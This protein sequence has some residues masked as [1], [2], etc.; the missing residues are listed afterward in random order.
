MMNNEVADTTRRVIEAVK[1]MSLE[2][3]GDRIVLIDNGDDSIKEWL[4]SSI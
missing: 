2:D 3:Y 4:G 1:G